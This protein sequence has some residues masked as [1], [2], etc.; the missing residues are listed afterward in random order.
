MRILASYNI[1]GGVGKTAA[2]V[3]LAYLAAQEGRRTLIWD[4]DPQAAATFYL[5]VRPKVKGGGKGLVKGKRELEDLVKAT[6]FEHLDLLPADFSFRNMDLVLE[7][8]KKP[9]KQLLR[10]L[11]SL[12]EEYDLVVLD[13]PP[14]IS[15][16]SENVFRAAD[17]LL[18]PVIPTTLSARTLEQLLA[19][20]EGHKA[21]SGLRVM[22]FFSMVDRRKR[23]HAELMAEL[24]RRFPGF[25]AT[26]IP[27]ASE[28]ERMG[29]HRTPLPVYAPA[30][31]AG[32]AYAELW[33]EV[34]AGLAAS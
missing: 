8:E 1:K 17:L 2:A 33:R 5:R 12:C 14:S 20:L 13:C 30:S 7:E 19:F 32:R 4:L 6:D 24:P 22:P 10:L 11:R 29:V 31:P 18:V 3:N 9:T 16:V 23:L 34:A 28:V 26:A 21:A 15:L 27:Y 25:L